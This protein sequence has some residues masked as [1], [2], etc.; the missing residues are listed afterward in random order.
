MRLRIYCLLAILCSVFTCYCQN[1]PGNIRPLGIGDTIPADLELTNVYNYPV[2]KI[3]L[4]DLKGKLVILDFWAT[5]CGSCISQFPKLDSLQKKY[6]DKIEILAVAIETRQDII[7]FIGRNKMASS[8]SFPFVTDDSILSKLFPHQ[9]IPHDVWIDGKG[10]VYKITDASY[11]TNDNVAK[12]LVGQDF[13]TVEKMDLQHYNRSRPFLTS[14]NNDI[15]KGLLY[16]SALFR[17]LG[18]GASKSRIIDSSTNLITLRYTDL[19]ILELYWSAVYS[20]SLGPNIRRRTIVESKDKNKYIIGDQQFAE[21][22]SKNTYC[23][24]ISAHE[25]TPD[26]ILKRWMLQDLNKYLHLTGVIENRSTK[27]IELQLQDKKLLL[28]KGGPPYEIIN[29]E[30]HSITLKNEPINKLIMFLNS[31]TTTDPD[32]P[33]ID[34]TGLRANIDLIATIKSGCSVTDLNR[35]LMPF[36]IKAIEREIEMKMFV[37]REE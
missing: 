19:P 6:K 27:I 35:L 16:R 2:S 17:F 37:L 1:S 29:S 3:R 34:G 5:W 25:S 7:R 12:Y 24:E 13:E 23:Y 36:G 4:S 30:N 11:I 31:Y 15:E 33:I 8:V 20:D 21:W 26:S 22:W 28:T 18:A 32:V 10:S 9:L 14:Q